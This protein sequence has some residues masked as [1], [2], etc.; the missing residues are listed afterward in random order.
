MGINPLYCVSSPS[1]K[2]QCGIKYTDIKL[3]TLQDKDLILI[4]EKNIRGGV[5]SVM[6]DRYVNSNDNEN[7]LCFDAKSFNGWGLSQMLPYDEIEMWHGHPVLYMNILEEI[8][9]TLHNSAI[10]YFVEVDIK[11]PDVITEKLKHL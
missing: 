9:N 6:G 3:K 10:G 11:Y 7:I 2:W 5:S 1:Y 8:S 4:L